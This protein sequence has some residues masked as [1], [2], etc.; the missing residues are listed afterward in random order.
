ML[1][2]NL[3]FSVCF[4]V[5]F[6]SLKATAVEVLRA[7]DMVILSDVP[8]M[9]TT[10]SNETVAQPSLDSAYEEIVYV[11][12]LK[13]FRAPGLKSVSEEIMQPEGVTADEQVIYI[14]VNPSYRR[15]TSYPVGYERREVDAWRHNGYQPNFGYESA[16]TRE[17]RKAVEEYKAKVANCRGNRQEKIEMEMSMLGGKQLYRN[18]AYLSETFG[19]IL[20][21]YDDLGLEIIDTFYYDD[22][23]VLRTYNQ[24]T[25]QFEVKSSAPNFD[26]KYC[27]EGFCSIESVAELQLEKFAE[28]EQY[29]YEL[30]DSSP[31]IV[32]FHG[33]DGEDDFI[34]ADDADVPYVDEDEF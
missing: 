12:P 26:T 8:A 34:V 32:P 14:D 6:C 16:D 25:P 5:V 19:E 28:F 30:L 20:Q 4:A 24:I 27:R 21:C 23:D 18:A 11:E 10:V 2:K 33:D 17:H 9:E 3:L 29:L 31:V 7:E 1:N 22:H 15:S 13:P